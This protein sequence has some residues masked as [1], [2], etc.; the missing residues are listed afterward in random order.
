[1]KGV[2]YKVQWEMVGRTGILGFL[3][4]D[5]REYFMEKTNTLVQW[6]MDINSM[7]WLEKQMEGTMSMEGCK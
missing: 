2:N 3:F 6:E 5:F 7:K 1:M 4:W